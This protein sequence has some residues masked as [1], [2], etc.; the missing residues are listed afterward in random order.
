MYQFRNVDDLKRLS[1][2]KVQTI[3]TFVF[4]TVSGP[5]M[6]TENICLAVRLPQV[7]ASAAFSA[8]SRLL[9]V[10]LKSKCLLLC[11]KQRRC[12][13]RKWSPG[14]VSREGKNEPTFHWL[15]VTSLFFHILEYKAYTSFFF[16]CHPWHSLLAG[17]TGQIGVLN[18]HTGW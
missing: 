11:V 12:W 18:N 7:L 9:S 1:Y 13:G 17:N 16:S 2:L 6:C 10:V 4:S 5:R 15:L 3:Q 8:A 14:E